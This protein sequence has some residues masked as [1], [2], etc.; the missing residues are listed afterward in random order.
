M[1]ANKGETE[2]IETLERCLACEADGR[3]LSSPVRSVADV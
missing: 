3:N 1:N 2:A